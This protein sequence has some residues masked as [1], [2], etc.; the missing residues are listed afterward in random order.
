MFAHNVLAI[1]AGLIYALRLRNLVKPTPPTLKIN[2]RKR[3]EREYLI[4]SEIIGIALAGGKASEEAQTIKEDESLMKLLGVGAP[5]IL[6][7]ED[8]LRNSLMAADE[9][10]VNVCKSPP[11]AIFL[12]VDRVNWKGDL[13]KIVSTVKELE[14]PTFVILIGEEV[15]LSS[16]ALI[17]VDPSRFTAPGKSKEELSRLLRELTSSIG[18]LLDVDG[19]K[20][21]MFVV[22][23]AE[24]YYALKDRESTLAHTSILDCESITPDNVRGMVRQALRGRLADI[25]EDG[26]FVIMR[27]REDRMYLWAAVDEVASRMEPLG[28]VDLPQ[29]KGLHLTLVIRGVE[30]VKLVKAE[31][32]EAPSHLP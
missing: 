28:Q 6:K 4:E 1:A 13:E 21:S 9:I 27:G 3:E 24:L 32:G 20:G 25:T 14:L 30:K 12:I 22:R 26:A 2:K 29:E 15:N 5:L 19:V 16:I 7:S 17:R 23:P 18:D 11:D 31:G 8:D 10:I